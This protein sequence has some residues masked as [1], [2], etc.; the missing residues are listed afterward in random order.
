MTYQYA[1]QYAYLFDAKLSDRSQE[2]WVSRLE[3]EL[4]RKQLSGQ[5]LREGSFRGLKELAKEALSKGAATIIIVGT[6]ESLIKILPVIA[7]A[8]VVIGYLPSE[9][10]VIAKELGIPEKLED[11]VNCLAARF[12]RQVDIGFIGDRPFLTEVIIRD[13]KAKLSIADKYTI[14]CQQDGA[15]HLVNMKAGSRF[16]D[17]ELDVFVEIDEAKKGLFRTPKKQARTHIRAIHGK[18]TSDS[19]IALTVDGTALNGSN[20][21]FS[22]KPNG[23]KWIVGRKTREGLQEK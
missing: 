11:S 9:P 2:R 19:P 13:P 21:D 14:S 3:V 16:D 15:M 23:L 18:V 10:S 8:N 20:I 22:L 7:E 1:Y 4:S 6:D 5:V 12:V 17:G